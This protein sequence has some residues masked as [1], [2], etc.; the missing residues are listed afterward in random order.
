VN[1]PAKKSIYRKARI[2][3]WSLIASCF[4]LF[5]MCLPGSSRYWFRQGAG[6][7]YIIQREAGVSHSV[8]AQ[9][10]HTIG[11]LYASSMVLGLPFPVFAL[12]SVVVALICRLSR[13]T[14]QGLLGGLFGAIVIG[15]WAFLAVAQHLLTPHKPVIASFVA[16]AFIWLAIAIVF[17]LP[18]VIAYVIRRIRNA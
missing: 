7:T 11:V 2:V 6:R 15:G 3:G 17:G 5:M 13:D 4:V 12:F 8:A 1:E 10:G 9:Q 18:L 14:R 16:T